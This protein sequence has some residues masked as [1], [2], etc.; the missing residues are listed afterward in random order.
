MNQLGSVM[1]VR[2]HL[3]SVH[4]VKSVSQICLDNA[5][6]VTMLTVMFV[7]EFMTK[8]VVL[9]RPKTDLTPSNKS[10]LVLNVK[11]VV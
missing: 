9:K 10:F 3:K 5:L 7:M 4:A 1:T 6:T 11:Y 8:T 2:T